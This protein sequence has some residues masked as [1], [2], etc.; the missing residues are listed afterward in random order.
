VRARLLLLRRDLSEAGLGGFSTLFLK[1]HIYLEL[2][3]KVEPGWR[4]DRAVLATLDRDLDVE[5]E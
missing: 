2:F 1:R 4:E 5:T 3:V